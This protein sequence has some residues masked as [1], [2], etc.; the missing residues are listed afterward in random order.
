MNDIN[1]AKL[2]TTTETPIVAIPCCTQ[3]V[4]PVKTCGSCG[5]EF[6]K[7]DK[8]FFKKTIKQK[9]AAGQ[10]VKYK[11]FRS[12]CKS[13]HAIE[14][15]NAQRLRRCKEMGCSIDEYEFYWKKQYTE[16]RTKYPEISHLPK[17]VR[18]TIKKRIRNG[19]KFTTYEK[20]KTDCRIN[21]SKAKR[22][23]DYGNIDFA[24]QKQKNRCGIINLTDGYV[25]ATLNSKVGDLPKEI[26]ETKRIILKLK[27]ELNITNIKI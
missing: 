22:K 9:N 23:Y 18:C 7:T 6:P 17:S 5:N 10:T 14:M 12:V 26:I 4:I 24:P 2:Q 16:T 25:A 19:Y 21:V 27:R 8:Y 3:A 11:S 13:C 20:Y 1:S 15:K